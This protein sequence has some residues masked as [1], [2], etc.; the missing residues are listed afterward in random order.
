MPMRRLTQLAALALLL[1]LGSVHVQAAT[2]AGPAVANPI[3]FV[4]QVP[5]PDDYTAIASVFGN[6]KADLESAGRGGDLWIRYGDGT[7]RNLTALAG[8]GV[9]AGIETGGAIG[10]RDPSVYWD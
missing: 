6:H 3:L 10:V 5:I 2:P 7:L 8:Y 1:T 4:T 9:A